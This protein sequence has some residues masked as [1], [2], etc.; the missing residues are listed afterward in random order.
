MMLQHHILEAT[1]G[2][3]IGV[4]GQG[5]HFFSGG[6]YQHP[7]LPRKQ[8]PKIKANKIEQKTKENDAKY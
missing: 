7:S 4:W 5:P 3:F 1:E 2:F 8:R 6:W